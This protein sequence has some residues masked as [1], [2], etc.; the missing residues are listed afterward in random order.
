[1]Q[2]HY[3]FHRQKQMPPAQDLKFKFSEKIDI[4]PSQ[5]FFLTPLTY[6]FVN[7]RPV[8]PGML[9]SLTSNHTWII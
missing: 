6:A 8:V 5:V 3:L 4:D 9:F 2:A 1:M 7:I